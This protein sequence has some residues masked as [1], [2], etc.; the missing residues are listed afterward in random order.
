MRIEELGHFLLQ[1]SGFTKVVYDD[2]GVILRNVRSQR[3][4]YPFDLPG[5]IYLYSKPVKIC[6]LLMLNL[7]S[8]TLCLFNSSGSQI[9][10]HLWGSQR[11]DIDW[12]LLSGLQRR[13]DFYVETDVSK[14]Y[15]DTIFRTKYF[16]SEAVCF[17]KLCAPT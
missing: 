3:R 5:I 6:H 1:S 2:G 4:L 12:T 8:S 15:N 14:D 16:I 9:S 17:F 11:E 10:I 7:H 13:L